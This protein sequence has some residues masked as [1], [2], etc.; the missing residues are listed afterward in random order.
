[1][2]HPAHGSKDCA[3]SLAGVVYGLTTRRETWL[4]F[5][6]PPTQIP[7]SVAQAMASESDADEE[8]K[9]HPRRPPQR[10]R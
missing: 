5:G 1:V 9:T 2:D 4:D 10:E 3:D 6:I 7:Q 8:V